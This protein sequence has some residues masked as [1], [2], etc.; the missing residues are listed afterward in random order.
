MHDEEPPQSKFSEVVEVGTASQT[1]TSSTLTTARNEN[2]QGMEV[3]IWGSA[4]SESHRLTN[5]ITVG[6]KSM[7]PVQN[8]CRN[9]DK[10]IPGT[11]KCSKILKLST[12]V[13][14]KHVHYLCSTIVSSIFIFSPH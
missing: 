5:S 12:L 2:L 11:F 7:S 14:L 9:R 3:E 10:I 13:I 6:A 8:L 4:L 1:E